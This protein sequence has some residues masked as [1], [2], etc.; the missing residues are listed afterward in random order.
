MQLPDFTQYRHKYGIKVPVDATGRTVDILF[1]VYTDHRMWPQFKLMELTIAPNLGPK[2]RPVVADGKHMVRT[3]I[4][5]AL[6]DAGWTSEL[7]ST[8]DEYWHPPVSVWSQALTRIES[9]GWK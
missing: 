9:G 6:R 1:Q 2:Q 4:R 7:T 3:A 5:N 8:Y